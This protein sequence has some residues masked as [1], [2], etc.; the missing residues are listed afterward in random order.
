V[1][2]FTGIVGASSAWAAADL[3][4][5][6]A[7]LRHVC[8]GGTAEGTVCCTDP[9]S[10]DVCGAEGTCVLDA[11]GKISAILTLIIDDDVS[12]QNNDVVAGRRLRGFTLLLETKGKK[13][14]ALLAQTFQNLEGTTLAEF[15]DNLEEGAADEFGFNA[16]EQNLHDFVLPNPPPPN[17]TTDLSWLIYRT[18]DPE[19]L[20]R[21]RTSAGLDPDGPEL[22]VIQPS[23]LKLDR[24]QDA[25]ATDNP[26]A[27]VL[28]VKMNTFFVAPKDP[29][30]F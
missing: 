1:L 13:T 28:R 8:E 23:R 24:Y 26:H 15:L 19:T 7:R 25:S 6:E 16:T 30:C 2:A 27:S 21:L 11:F 20:R 17:G 29:S 3:A 18:I 4:F 14:G 5:R 10:P 22:L 9:G 12:K